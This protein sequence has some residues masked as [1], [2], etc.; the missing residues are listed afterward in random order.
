MKIEIGDKIRVENLSDLL[1]N[2]KGFEDF[3]GIVTS[4]FRH[5]FGYSGEVVTESKKRKFRVFDTEVHR[6]IP[7][8]NEG[9]K[10]QEIDD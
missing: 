7:I 10:K 9:E 8:P 2:S 6:L 5:V 3:E 4:I 1:R